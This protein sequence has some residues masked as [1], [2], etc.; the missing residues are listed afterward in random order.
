MK[1]VWIAIVCNLLLLQVNSQ[2]KPTLNGIWEW[3][4]AAMQGKPVI[5]KFLSISDQNGSTENGTAKLTFTPEAVQDTYA[6]WTAGTR[7]A[8]EVFYNSIDKYY[9]IKV[10]GYRNRNAKGEIIATGEY[11]VS[12]NKLPNTPNHIINGAL[13]LR[14]WNKPNTSTVQNRGGEEVLLTGQ[15]INKNLAPKENTAITA[16]NA[17]TIINAFNPKSIQLKEPLDID[18]PPRKIQWK[19]T[20]KITD[21]EFETLTVDSEKKA[22]DKESGFDEL[23]RNKAEYRGTFSI[24]VFAP[25]NGNFIKRWET[26]AVFNYEVSTSPRLLVLGLKQIVASKEN[27]T[28][29]FVITENEFNTMNLRIFGSLSEIDG[30]FEAPT[31]YSSSVYRQPETPTTLLSNNVFKEIPLKSLLSGDNVIDIIKNS[32]TF[33]LHFTID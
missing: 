32:K 31:D 4:A 17:Q 12:F 9:Y 14:S 23:Y 20:L 22:L 10:G 6:N 8:N 15:W 1:K 25:V 18:L 33:R 13:I 30:T 28:K 29:S 16:V 24:G 5:G 3:D 19:P 21:I 7:T 27:Y 11:I 26:S 2:Q